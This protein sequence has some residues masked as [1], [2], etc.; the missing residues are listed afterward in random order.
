MIPVSNMR[1]RILITRQVVQ[2][3]AIGNHKNVQEPFC[4]R[5]AYA[6]RQSGGEEEAAGVVREE[7]SIYFV[8]R[9]DELTRQI[10]STGF[11]VEFHGKTYDITLVDNYKFRNESLTLYAK[12]KRHD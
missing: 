4:S 3:D 9:F 7:D 5:W 1:E 12:E 10:T 6:N 11:Q 8:V 2:K